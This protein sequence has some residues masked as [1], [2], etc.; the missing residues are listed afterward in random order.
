[1]KKLGKTLALL[2]TVLLMLVT[3]ITFAVAQE[4]YQSMTFDEIVELAKG[5]TVTFYGWG[6]SDTRNRWLEEVY[7]PY[8]KETYDVDVEIVGMDIDQILSQLSNEKQAGLEDGDIDMI[9]ING[10]N[11]KTA[12]E[13]DFLYG[14]INHFLPN[15]AEYIDEADPEIEYDF[16]YPIDGYETPYGKAQIVFIKDGAVAEETPTDAASFLEFVKAHP[17]K[18]TYPALPDFTGSAFVRNIIYEFVDPSEFVGL[19]ADKEVVRELI[20]PA[21]DYLKELNPYLWN[22]GQT[23]PSGSPELDNMFMDGEVI[24]NISYNPFE[25]ALGIEEGRYPE[26]AETFIF[27]KGTVGNTSFIAIAANSGNIP[28]ALVAINAM[29][30]PEMQLS[31]YQELKTLPVLDNS[32]LSEEHVADFAA[33]DMGQGVLTQDVLLERRLPEMPAELV[34]IIEEIWAEEV[35]GQ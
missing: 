23:F 16:G 34:P 14:P 30:T 11:F 31:Q 20:R 17:G 21:L 18:V 33:V 6:G 15:Y 12:R 24:F 3:N 2:F 19:E 22:E 4:D 1:M 35:V 10:E 9:W 7:A 26:T 27:D 8:V 13:N 5:T 25:V 32:K 29:L 28:G